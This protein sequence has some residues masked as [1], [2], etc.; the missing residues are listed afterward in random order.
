MLPFSWSLR[1]RPDS[2]RERAELP[3]SGS[4]RHESDRLLERRGEQ[5]RML[6]RHTSWHDLDSPR[7][8]LDSL[9]STRLRFLLVDREASQWDDDSPDQPGSC[10]TDSRV[11]KKNRQ[12]PE[13]RPTLW[14]HRGGP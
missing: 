9:A 1:F 12:C 3:P 11:G 4:Y 2:A 8:F 6:L 5:L 14:Y 10:Q 13:T 7:Q